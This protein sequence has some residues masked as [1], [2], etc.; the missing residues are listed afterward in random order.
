MKRSFSFILSVGCV[1]VTLWLS[2]HVDSFFFEQNAQDYMQES[3]ILYK[4][5]GQ[6]RHDLGAMLYLKADE[7]YHGGT[8]HP[9]GQE[10]NIDD[11]AGMHVEKHKS[12]AN[13]KVISN[14]DIFSHINQA[15]KHRSVIHL[16]GKQESE[17]LPWFYLATLI[18][19]HYIR[20]Y[21]VGGYWLG[22]R[23]GK[24]AQAIKFLRKG[25]R[26]NPESWPIYSQLGDIYF[27]AEKDYEKAIIYFKHA[28]LLMDKQKVDI[29]ERKHILVFLAAAYEKRQDY[30]NAVH[31]YRQLYNISKQDTQLKNKINLLQNLIKKKPMT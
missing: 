2:M 30:H 24:T 26:Y 25:L 12:P 6:L 19:P 29:F 28:Y 4:M 23:L 13:L 31:F 9:A 20:A 16:K 21:T 5:L 7:Y 11:E 10:H 1:F 27:L 17:V 22:M 8:K 18:D 3:D 15:I 14:K